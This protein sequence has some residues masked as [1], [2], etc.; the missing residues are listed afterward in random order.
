[1]PP[2]TATFLIAN[3]CAKNFLLEKDTKR[4]Q[5]GLNGLKKKERNI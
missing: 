5:N 1:M 3:N 2:Q 4:I